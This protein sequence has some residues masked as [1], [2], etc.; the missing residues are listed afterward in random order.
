[1]DTNQI[2]LLVKKYPDKPWDWEYLSSYI[3]WDIIRDNPDK[4]WCWRRISRRHDLTWDIFLILSLPHTIHIWNWKVLSKNDNITWD[5]IQ[6]NPNLPWD[7]ESISRNPNIISDIIQDNLDKPWDWK[8]L[9]RNKYRISMVVR[10]YRKKTKKYI[11]ALL[12][13]DCKLPEVIGILICD[14]I[15]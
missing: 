11:Y 14:F 7:W 15:Y 6:D 12:D 9:S 4:P 3:S 1:M 13:K 2:I 8:S 10:R 5:I